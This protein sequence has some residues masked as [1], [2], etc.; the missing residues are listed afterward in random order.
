M[1]FSIF[2]GAARLPDYGIVA[3]AAKANASRAVLQPRLRSA[4]AHALTRVNA[5]C[6]LRTTE[7]RGSCGFLCGDRELKDY[8]FDEEETRRSRARLR[9]ASP[10]NRRVTSPK[11]QDFRAQ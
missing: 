7:L 3:A 5:P 9:C 4:L 11:P 6:V 10:S 2:E 8:R 1:K